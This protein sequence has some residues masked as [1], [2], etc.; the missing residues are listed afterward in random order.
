M[1]IQ[2][3]AERF[4][5]IRKIEPIFSDDSYVEVDTLRDIITIGLQFNL[6]QQISIEVIEDMNDVSQLSFLAKDWYRILHER[7][8]QSEVAFSK[9]VAGLK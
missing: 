7:L 5:I 8:I 3:A 6:E 4:P 9:K 1:K 2:E